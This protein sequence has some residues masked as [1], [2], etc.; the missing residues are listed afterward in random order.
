M[1]Q[2]NRGNTRHKHQ[3][4]FGHSPRVLYNYY[5]SNLIDDTTTGP[6][7]PTI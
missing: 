2:T 6:P 5:N 4:V 7:P 3:I 1:L